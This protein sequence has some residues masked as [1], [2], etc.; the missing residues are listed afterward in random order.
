MLEMLFYQI[1]RLLFQDTWDNSN[2][3]FYIGD[4]PAT[5]IEQWADEIAKE[6]GSQIRHLPLGIIRIGPDG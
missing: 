4:N 1:E 2:K 6:I 5:N 3:I